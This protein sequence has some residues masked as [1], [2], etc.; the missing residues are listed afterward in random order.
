MRTKPPTDSVILDRAR[1]LRREMT[2]PERKL[3]RFLRERPLVGVKFRRQVPVGNFIADFCCGEHQLIV[4]LDGGQHAEQEDADASRSR[5]LAEK[6]FRV[7][8]FWN[9]QVLNGAEF[10]VEEILKAIALDARAP[11]PGARDARRP[12]PKGEA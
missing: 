8:R 11:S 3:W 2:E 5:F 10:V 9:D 7:L 6:G 12:L 4:E 1:R